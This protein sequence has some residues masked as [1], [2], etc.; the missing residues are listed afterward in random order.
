MDTATNAPLF[1]CHQTCNSSESRSC[2]PEVFLGQGPGGL[3]TL[4]RPGCSRTHSVAVASPSR[5]QSLGAPWK[6]GRRGAWVCEDHPD[7][8]WD[9]ASDMED[10]CHCGGAGMPCPICNP[11]DEVT[12]RRCPKVFRWMSK[13]RIGRG[14]RAQA[15]RARKPKPLPKRPA[16]SRQR[17]RWRDRYRP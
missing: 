5:S 10:A 1:Y 15:P 13:T 9:G 3:P 4:D 7:K 17:S 8:P 11:S 16:N 12:A 14:R 6:H 2:G